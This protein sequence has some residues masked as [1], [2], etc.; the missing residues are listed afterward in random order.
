MTNIKHLF[1]FF[2]SYLILNISI[3]LASS[4]IM[5]KILFDLN[6]QKFFFL[7]HILL[8]S[9]SYIHKRKLSLLFLRCIWHFDIVCMI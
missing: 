1:Q 2:L 7:F 8:F 3:A 4:V 6:K 9:I 5:K